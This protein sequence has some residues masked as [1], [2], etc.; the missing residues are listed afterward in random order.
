MKK[1]DRCGG[2]AGVWQMSRFNTDEC[3]RSCIETER[4]HHRYQ[5]AYDAELREVN[6]G[7]HNY[8]GIGLPRD[9]ELRYKVVLTPNYPYHTLTGTRV[10]F[11]G[12]V[13]GIDHYYGHGNKTLYQVA[14]GGRLKATPIHIERDSPKKSDTRILMEMAGLW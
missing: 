10:V 9:L 14:S 3:C 1:C 8:A 4:R 12:H 2:D 7:N 13:V 5:E 6:A 11:L